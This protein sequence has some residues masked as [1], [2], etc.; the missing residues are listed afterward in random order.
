MLDGLFTDEERKALLEQ[1]PKAQ[2]KAK[3]LPAVAVAD[4][5]DTATLPVNDIADQFSDMRIAAAFSSLFQETLRYWVE[6]GK[7]LVF[8]GHRWTTDAPGGAFPFIRLLI[9]EL[10]RRALEC[11]DYAQRAETLKTITKLEAHPRQ[12]TV[13]SAAK[14]RPDLIVTAADL[15]QHGMLLTASNGT[16][17]LRT[18][19]LQP[20]DARDLITRWSPIEYDPGAECPLFLAF[21]DR[22]FEGNSEIIGYL[23]RFAGYCLTGQT[24]E[25]VLL[26]FYGLGANGKSVLVNVLRHL[27]GDF[28]SGATPDLLMARDGRTATNDVAA[29]RGARLVTVSEFDDGER[30]AEAQIKTLTGGDAVTCRHLYREFFSYVPSFKIILIGNH[31]PKIRGTDHGIWRRLHLL[32]FGVTIPEDERDPHLQEKLLKELPGILAWAVRGCIEWQQTGLAAPDE[33]KSAVSEYRKSEDIFDQ[34]L[35]EC[36]STGDQFVTPINDLINS[37]EAFSRWKNITSQRFGR[38]LSEAGFVKERSNGNTRWRGIGLVTNQNNS[39]WQDKYDN[40]DRPF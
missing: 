23:Q 10:Y 27:L 15:D 25:Q 14:N 31:K 22:I 17:N 35:D 1:R 33:I 3:T 19:T 32:N 34:W 5:S 37:F 2:K 16:L 21:L 36:C 9:E 20:S 12:E 30:L 13:L 29:L 26:F 7:W 8:D 11:P 24:S 38:L 4:D 28:A 40:D 39:G 6:A 18:G